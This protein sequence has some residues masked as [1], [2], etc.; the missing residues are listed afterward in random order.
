M[1][2]V[3]P[4]IR[5]CVKNCLK[6]VCDNIPPSQPGGLTMEVSV[7]TIGWMV[8]T[9]LFVLREMSGGPIS[10]LCVSPP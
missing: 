5:D 4:N 10:Q 9:K 6:L 7:R 2:V 3:N 8:L 1:K